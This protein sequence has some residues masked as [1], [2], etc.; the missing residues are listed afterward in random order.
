MINS[1]IYDSLLKPNWTLHDNLFN[2]PDYKTFRNDR[3]SSAGGLIAY[4]RS[5]LPARRRYDLE[6]DQ[7]I[8]TIVLDVQINDRKW[9]L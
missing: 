8:G 7:P 1:R 4:V 6:L 2:I 5:S 9:A 3:N